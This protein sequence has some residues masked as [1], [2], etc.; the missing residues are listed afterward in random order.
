[1]ITP[2][3]FPDIKKGD[4]CMSYAEEDAEKWKVR[5]Q[6][7]YG[8]KKFAI[9]LHKKLDTEGDAWKLGAAFDMEFNSRA[10]IE[11]ALT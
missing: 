2:F 10:G 9:Y 4:L 11:G 5:L 7:I 1:M 3:D 8:G 6:G